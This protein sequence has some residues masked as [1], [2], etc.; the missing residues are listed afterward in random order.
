VEAKFQRDEAAH[1]LHARARQRRQGRQHLF[2]LIADGR[3]HRL[4]EDHGTA[5]HAR[6]PVS[7]AAGIEGPG[8]WPH[9][10][11]T[12]MEIFDRLENL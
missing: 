8:E 10:L 11:D 4:E 12:A 5:A 3:H 1:P 6:G 2:P 9:P 7:A